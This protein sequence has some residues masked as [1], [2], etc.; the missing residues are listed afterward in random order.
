MCKIIISY[1]LTNKFNFTLIY[2]MYY[3][4]NTKVKRE[5]NKWEH[6]RKRKG[7]REKVIVEKD[8]R[9]ILKRNNRWNN[10]GGDERNMSEREKR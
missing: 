10:N 5:K 2:K 9:K 6:E 7:M 1:K 8:E 3:K 4:N